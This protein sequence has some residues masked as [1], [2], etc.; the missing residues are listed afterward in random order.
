MKAI[1][2]RVN[3][4]KW[5]RNFGVGVY[6]GIAF[7]EMSFLALFE[8]EYRLCKMRDPLANIQYVIGV[9]KGN[10]ELIWIFTLLSND[11]PVKSTGF[12]PE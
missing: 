3:V 12:T 9:A 11:H 4:V 7:G 2:A 10:D 8:A 6:I 1:E 5:I